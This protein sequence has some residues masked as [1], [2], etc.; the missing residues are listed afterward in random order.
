MWQRFVAWCAHRE[1]DLLT[2]D[3]SSL[4]AFLD[5]LGGAQEATPRYTQRMLRLIQRLAA[6]DASSHGHQLNPAIA[7]VAALP[8]YRFADA[9]LEEP[10]PEFLR[11]SQARR[12]MDFVTRRSDADR[13]SGT[14]QDVRNR[15]AVAL[16]LGAG[17]TPGEARAL[18]LDAVIVEG[19]SR[20]GEPWAIAVPANGN[21]AA[22]QTPLARW[23]GRQLQYW[24]EVRANQAIPGSA[25]FPSVRSGKPWSKPSAAEA[26]E[27]VLE[28]AGISSIGGSFKLR[29]T[30]ALRQLTRHDE[31]TVARWLGVTDP[32]IM[33]RYRRVLFQPVDV[34]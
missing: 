10:L 33:E 30:F 24:L 23:A 2:I 18:E 28:A 9:A 7:A 11:A 15:T 12:L 17:L 27:S 13:G 25:L 16:Q 26:F 6:H 19:G 22:R 14:W 3:K 29:H 4:L 1:V 34:I 31:D 21:Y 32:A 20:H 8:R 5:S